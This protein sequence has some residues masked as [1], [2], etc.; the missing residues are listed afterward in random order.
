[1]NQAQAEELALKALGWLAASDDL[2]GVF[3]GATGASVEDVKAQAGDPGFLGGVLDFLMM[4]DDWVRGFCD[5]IEVD[6][7]APS[8]A[9]QALPGGDLPNW[10]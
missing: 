4:N 10:T 3:M 5:D 9:R 2:M 7:M 1:M 6:Y 8:Q